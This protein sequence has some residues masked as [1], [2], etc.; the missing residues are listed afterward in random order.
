MCLFDVVTPVG[1][2]HNSVS[3][4]NSRSSMLL[5][6]CL[7]EL[8]LV[9]VFERVQLRAAWS[10]LWIWA[11]NSLRDALREADEVLSRSSGRTDTGKEF[12]SYDSAVARELQ[13]TPCFSDNDDSSHIN[14]PIDNLDNVPVV[15]LPT[16]K[17]L[18]SG[19]SIDRSVPSIAT[20]SGGPE[21]CSAGTAPNAFSVSTSTK[22][23]ISEEVN[24]LDSKLCE[25]DEISGEDTAVGGY[26][27]SHSEIELDTSYGMGP[28]LS[29]HSV[30]HSVSQSSHPPHG[31]VF[32]ATMSEVEYIRSSVGTTTG[33]NLLNTSASVACVPEALDEHRLE[34]GRR[35]SAEVNE[36][37]PPIA[38]ASGGPVSDRNSS[39]AMGRPKEYFSALASSRS[40]RDKH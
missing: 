31:A 16:P 3:Y 36:G 23:I 12:A 37:G 8:S 14:S 27:R 11:V 25:L 6:D 21:Y 18:S 38:Y 29:Q 40:V 15:A 2:C 32:L 9:P 4:V 24:P 34:E 7:S 10:R 35:N 5:S 22:N 19:T 26:H 39:A 13:N 20:A 28:V 17:K 30:Y 1:P 33:E